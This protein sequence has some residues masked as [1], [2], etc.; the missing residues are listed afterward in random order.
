MSLRISSKGWS[1]GDV[2][3]P[4]SIATTF[5]PAFVSGQTAVP[6]AAPVPTMTTSTGFSTSGMSQPPCQRL[7]QRDRVR[8]LQARAR[9]DVEL[10]VVG[11]DDEPR[12]READELPADEVRVPAVHRVA[13][14]ALH[15]VRPDHLEHGL[16]V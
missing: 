6:P 3:G 10:L 15:R 16:R 1:F 9:D 11:A 13:E 7:E 2:R 12:P 14:H 4:A 8:R 5:I